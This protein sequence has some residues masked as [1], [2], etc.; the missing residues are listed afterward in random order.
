MYVATVFECMREPGAVSIRDDAMSG[1]YYKK[2]PERVW[3][4]KLLHSLIIGLIF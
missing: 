2:I 3:D 4:L 1:K